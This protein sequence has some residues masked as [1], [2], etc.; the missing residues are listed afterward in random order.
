MHME[1]HEQTIN[2]TWP[3]AIL[4]R[5]EFLFL[6]HYYRKSWQVKREYHQSYFNTNVLQSWKYIYSTCALN[7]HYCINFFFLATD[8]SCSFVILCFLHKP[9]SI[10]AG[11]GV[12]S[13]FTLFFF[14]ATMAFSSSLP[15]SMK[16]SA[17]SILAL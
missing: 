12:N 2:C 17:T 4:I 9:I 13:F 6:M 16:H 14:P 10:F 8:L 7:V 11:A 1:N 15:S 5:F 3:Y